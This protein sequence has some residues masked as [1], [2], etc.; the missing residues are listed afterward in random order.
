MYKKIFTLLFSFA[1]LCISTAFT[2]QSSACNVEEALRT[3]KKEL[4]PYSFQ[5]RKT[6][7]F[8]YGSMEQMKEYEVQLFNGEVYR[9]IFNRTYSPGVVIKVYNKPKSHK[10]RKL[11][12]NSEEDK[13]ED[14]LVYH[15][16]TIP[17][18]YI[19]LII[20]A[21]D[22]GTKKE[23]CTTIMIGYELTFVD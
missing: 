22:S 19:D 5:D 23:G 8:T 9:F 13:P 2:P 7:T 1:L 20:P 21:S 6:V 3:C 12:Y 17:Y 11:L 16:Q 10:K 4:L 15:P 14:I 18:V